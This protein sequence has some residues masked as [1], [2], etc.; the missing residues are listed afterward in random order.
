MVVKVLDRIVVDPRWNAQ[1]RTDA[2][3]EP[4][5]KLPRATLRVALLVER[6]DEGRCIAHKIIVYRN[7]LA[8]RICEDVA[9]GHYGT[10][11]A[12]VERIRAVH[13]R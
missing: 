11:I 10:D 3:V 1:M 7:C 8:I 4:K 6:A 2:F 5:C 9:D 12:R 13:A